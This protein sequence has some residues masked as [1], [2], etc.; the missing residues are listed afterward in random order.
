[1]QLHKSMRGGRFTTALLGDLPRELAFSVP[2]YRERA[3]SVTKGMSESGIDALLVTYPPNVL[4]LSGFQTFSNYGGECLIL[5]LEGEPTLVVHPPELGGALLHSWI[6]DQA[7]YPPESSRESYLATV[8]R[9]KKLSDVR[10]GVEKSTQGV[11]AQFLVHL[12]TELPKAA[13]VDGSGLVEVVKTIKS[14]AEIEHIRTAARMTNAGIAAAIDA[15]REEASDNDLA[16]AASQAMIAAGSEYMCLSPIVTSGRRSGILHSTHKRNRLC[17]GDVVLLEM[18]A[19][20]QRYTAPTMRTISIGEPPAEARKMADACIQALNNVLKTIRPGIAA[21]AVAQAG[22]Q[23]MREAGKDY[24]FHGNFGYAVGAGFP[25]T[26]GDGT[27]AIE[28]G[29]E[30]ILQPGMVFHHPVALRRL[31]QYGVAFSETTVVTDAG[32]E[33]LTSSPRELVVKTESPR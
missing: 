22:W 14:S 24:V 27:V 26:W 3:S 1:M 21:D 33:V 23:G 8:L 15:A 7:C 10:I 32:C 17:H 4:Y 5:P 9:D 25:P 2:E 6:E 12:R 11:P 20:V 19:C 13:L 16:A 18:G 31:G 30:T 28:S 29:V